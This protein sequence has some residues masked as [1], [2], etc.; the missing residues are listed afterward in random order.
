[1]DAYEYKRRDFLKKLGLIAGATAVATAGV[2]GVAEIISEQKETFILTQ[3]Q[4]DFMDK[5]EKWLE[6]FH[7]MAKF[8][9]TDAENLENNQKLMALANKAQLWQKELTEYMKDEN[10]ARYYMV[11]TER[12]TATI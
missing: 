8:Q 2:T 7:D 4:K 12:V 10:F 3:A 9:K 11:V 1:M 6:E 5:Y